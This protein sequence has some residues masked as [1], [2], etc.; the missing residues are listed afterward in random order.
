MLRSKTQVRNRHRARFLGIVHKVTLGIIVGIFADYLDGVLIRANR[1]I[2]TQSIKQCPNNVVSLCGKIGIVI[3]TGLADVVTDANCKMI[4]QLVFAEMIEDSLD[5][6]RGKIF[7]RQTIPSSDYLWQRFQLTPAFTQSFMQCIDT[8]EIKR[9]TGTARFLG[10][11]QDRDGFGC[12]RQC[13]HKTL[14]IKRPIQSDLNHPDFFILLRKIVHGLMGCFA[15]RGH[16]HNEALGIGCAVIIEKVVCPTGDFGK[17]VH[18]VLCD[19]GTG[20]VEWI[21]RFSC[22]EEDVRI[23]RRPA[24]N[25]MIRRKCTSAMVQYQFIVVKHGPDFIIA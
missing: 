14:C 22:L 16:Q 12:S 24:Q 15:S 9:F 19:I 11:I 10:A 21:D 17:S 13:F 20:R 1:A 23:L 18:D 4:F 3:Q 2:G 7:R 5:H 6:G 25:G 8:I